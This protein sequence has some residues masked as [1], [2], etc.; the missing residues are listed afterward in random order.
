MAP[1]TS[2]HGYYLL[3]ADG[4]VFTFGDAKFRGSTGSMRLN[5]PVISMA[6]SPSG[7]G[8][9]LIAKD[10][11]VFSFHVPFYGSLP[12]SG[13]CRTPQ[14]AQIRPTLTGDGYFMLA[15]NGTIWAFGDAQSGGGAPP[16][17]LN[18]AATDLAVRP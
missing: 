14:G 18:N 3:A 17:P 11:G 9:W 6:T 8:Y 10:G 12:G 7:T 15:T 16:L 2:G 4:G 1:T 13:L 5:A